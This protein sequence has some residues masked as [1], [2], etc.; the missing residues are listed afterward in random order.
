VASVVAL[1]TRG[2][3]LTRIGPVE[4][5]EG[6]E[7]LGAENQ[8]LKESLKNAEQTIDILR[9]ELMESNSLMDRK[10]KNSEGME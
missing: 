6:V 3:W 10:P 1:I 7:D 8:R 9:Y 2:Q 5:S 4:V